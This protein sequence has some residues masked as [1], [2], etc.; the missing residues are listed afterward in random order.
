[1]IICNEC[2]IQCKNF[3]ALSQHVTRTHKIDTESYFLKHIG[4]KG[5][6]L[7][8]GKDTRFINM[9]TGYRPSCGNSCA[10][11]IK[12]KV[13]KEDEQKFKSFN[14]KVA[15]NMRT[16]WDT[17]DRTEISKKAGKTVKDINSKL[18]PE[19]RKVKY[20]RNPKGH[21]KS[22]LT[23]WATA[24]EEQKGIAR[25]KAFGKAKMTIASRSYTVTDEMDYQDTLWYF[26]N[27]DR[28]MLLFCESN[29][30]VSNT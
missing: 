20:T 14:D 10:G 6:C 2:S 9:N 5:S 21:S 8:C 26:A 30:K 13:L 18:A 29:E 17:E 22:L 12:R 7:N 3:V 11:I 4:T 23:W 28:L 25:I 16:I 27:K 19:V 1:M 15:K 24:N